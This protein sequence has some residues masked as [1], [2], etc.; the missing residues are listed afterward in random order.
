MKRI[1][2]TGAQGQVGWEL[3]RSLA[4]L[5]EVIATTRAD[6]DL[7]RPDVLLQTIRTLRPQIIVNAAAYTAVDRAEQESELALRVNADAPGLLAEAA[8]SLDALLVHYS[9]DYVF[10][11]RLDRPY[12]ENDPPG[13]LGVYG[14]SKFAGEQAIAASG[15]CH[16]ILRTSWVYGA[17]GHN[18]LLT[19]LRLAREERPLR[20]V[21]D[22]TGAPTWCRML[23]EATALALADPAVRDKSGLYHL[24]AAG[25]TTWHGFAQ[26]ALESLRGPAAPPVTPIGTADYPLPARRPAHS[27]LDSSRF[28]ASFGLALPDWRDSL[29]LCLQEM[30]DARP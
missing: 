26:A 10:D 3:R 29:E 4:P 24:S 7:A 6:G 30:P 12:R 2:L 1:L 21:A 28:R 13:P 8:R 9:T 17:R 27:C 15:C 14:A 16:L 23:A 11:G 20:I 18:F 22:Q 5:G 19:I 25:A